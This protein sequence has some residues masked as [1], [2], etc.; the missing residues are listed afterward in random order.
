MKKLSVR[1]LVLLALLIAILVVLGLVN[2]PQPA[3]LSR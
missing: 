1:E 3:G 2:I